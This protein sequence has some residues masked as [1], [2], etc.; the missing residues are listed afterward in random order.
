MNIYLSLLTFI[1]PSLL[2]SIT[3][4]ILIYTAKI[5]RRNKAFSS[6]EITAG[7]RIQTQFLPLLSSD[8]KDIQTTTKTTI[9]KIQLFCC[10]L[11]AED[12][13][14]DYFDT[15]IIDDKHISFI[16]CDV[17]GHGVPAAMIMI[18]IATIFTGIFTK[19]EINNP[20]QNYNV[21]E[22][23][24]L[25]NDIMAN[26]GLKDRFA[27]LS[28]GILNT[29]SGDCYISAAGD[30]IINMYKSD[31]KK[32]IHINL[33]P[34]PAAGIFSSNFIEQTVQYK[35][36]HI[37]MNSGDILYL[38]TDGIEESS[39][40]IG[41]SN[42][43]IKLEYFGRNRIDDIINAVNNKD[44]YLFEIPENKKTTILHFDFTQQNKEKENDPLEDSIIA[45]VSA[46]KLFRIHQKKT[47]NNSNLKIDKA[48]DSF[49]QKKLKEY[50]LLFSK[51]LK[52]SINNKYC[53]YKKIT[54]EPQHDD[55]TIMGIKK[56]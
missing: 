31:L 12:L 21:D 19:W 39:R 46:E 34:V 45:L 13:S 25:L 14:G 15:H 38:Y 44:T 53:I 18:Q 26:K 3:L 24:K 56:L 4:V 51:K 35:T 23:L 20:I 55:L 1:V 40:R 9:N 41:K 33:P 17:S 7:K 22:A 28:L 52:I 10:Y 36:T 37:K 6:R 30:N 8:S 16:K 54:E 11:G 47:F 2:L 42:K 29:E 32:V 48:L 43:T 49:L 27:A 5:E 50:N